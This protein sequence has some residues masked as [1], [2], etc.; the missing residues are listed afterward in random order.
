MAELA[1]AVLFD[2]RD[3]DAVVVT[4]PDA[5]TF[6][7]S[8]CSQD[9]AG[10]ADGEGAHALLLQPQGKLIAD[11][12]VLRVD[13][14]LWLDCE[15]GVGSALASTLNRFR[16]R[17]KAEVL[18]RSAELGVIEVR[19][20]GALATSP[21]PVPETQHAHRTWPGCAGV[22]I[23][24]AD[25]PDGTPGF[26]VVGPIVAGTHAGLDGLDGALAEFMAAGLGL[27]SADEHEYR[28]IVAGVVRQGLDTNDAT[29]PQEAYLERTAVS[30]TKGCF[31]GQELVCRIDSF[32]QVPRLLRLVRLD[33]RGAVEPGSEVVHEGAGVGAVTSVATE[34]GGATAVALASVK[35]TIAVP[36]AVTIAG[37]AG[38]L[39]V[40]PGRVDDDAPKPVAQARLGLRAKR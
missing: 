30:F 13:N 24:R 19:G 36:S 2:R 27:A 11:F 32:G 10:L 6:L 29:I 4:G 21:V 39:E 26:D 28:R 16:I 17:V 31:V 20:P 38:R 37:I 35:R 25:W 1:G 15:A 3:R 14:E 33:A 18:D 34:P 22:R 23:V 8:L 7:H 9:V 5:A 40:L 12:R